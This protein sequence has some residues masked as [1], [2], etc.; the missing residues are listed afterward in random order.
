VPDVLLDPLE[1]ESL[2]E[3]GGEKTF[4]LVEEELREVEGECVLL[5][6]LL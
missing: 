1:D 6:T 3:E 2:L 4:T 5:P